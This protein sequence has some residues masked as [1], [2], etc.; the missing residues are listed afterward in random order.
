MSAISEREAD[1]HAVEMLGRIARLAHT[2]PLITDAFRTLLADEL[3]RD[4][5]LRVIADALKSNR[6]GMLSGLLQR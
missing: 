4:A 6:H 3:I 1:D 2:E 5:L